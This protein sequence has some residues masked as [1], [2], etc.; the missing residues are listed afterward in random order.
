MPLQK[1]KLDFEQR[2]RASLLEEW[3]LGNPEK[4]A[5]ELIY[6]R[7]LLGQGYEKWPKKDTP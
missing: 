1:I 3:V 2:Q 4:A 5:E 7:D 6:L